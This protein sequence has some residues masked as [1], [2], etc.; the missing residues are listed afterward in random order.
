MSAPFCRIFCTRPRVT[1]CSSAW[2]RAETVAS[3]AGSRATVWVVLAALLR[4]AAHRPSGF[5]PG[6]LLVV[7]APTA[8]M[9]CAKPAT[10]PQPSELPPI[11]DM[12]SPPSP[13]AAP[14]ASA[15]LVA[16]EASEEAPAVDNSTPRA[17]DRSATPPASSPSAHT[18][19]MHPRILQSEPGAC[20]ICGMDLVPKE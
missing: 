15:D 10:A 7:L 12:G 2:V 9:G 1:D 16:V 8:A 19:S 3:V 6:T 17:P 4:I 11:V 20:P 18:C 14:P 5:G 13:G